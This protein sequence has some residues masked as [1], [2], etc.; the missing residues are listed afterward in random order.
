MAKRRPGLTDKSVEQPRNFRDCLTPG[1]LKNMINA[2]QY[3]NPRGYPGLAGLQLNRPAEKRIITHETQ[4][5]M[6]LE[7]QMKGT[8]FK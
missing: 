2:E 6:E 3:D 5:K 1:N 8:G 7:G 4:H